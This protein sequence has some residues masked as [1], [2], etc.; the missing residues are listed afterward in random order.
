MVF[1]VYAREDEEAVS[2]LLDILSTAGVSAQRDQVILEG[3]DPW[4][5]KIA[6]AI[7]AADAV[8]VVWSA[9]AARSSNVD[10]E[11]NQSIAQEKRIIPCTLDETSLPALLSAYS[12]IPLSKPDSV[13]RLAQ[14]LSGLVKSGHHRMDDQALIG[15]LEKFTAE[16][17]RQSAREEWLYWLKRL[18][19]S[20]REQPIDEVIHSLQHAFFRCSPRDKSLLLD[21]LKD[22]ITAAHE[23]GK[24]NVEEGRALSRLATELASSFPRTRWWRSVLAFF[25]FKWVGL[26]LLSLGIYFGVVILLNDRLRAVHVHYAAEADRPF[27]DSLQVLF[28]AADYP[29]GLAS[30]EESIKSG[31]IRYFRPADED[32]ALGIAQILDSL[33]RERG[34]E[35]EFE[36]VHLPGY[37]NA[38]GTVEVWLPFSEPVRSARERQPSP[39]SGAESSC[40]DGRTA[41]DV[42]RYRAWF[43]PYFT[44][45]LSQDGRFIHTQRDGQVIDVS[46]RIDFRS[47]NGALE[48]ARLVRTS[49]SVE[50][51]GTIGS[52]PSCTET[53]TL[54]DF[55]EYFDWEDIDRRAAYQPG[56]PFCIWEP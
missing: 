8:I 6:A 23:T 27:V 39:Q 10:R 15:E 31:T 46:S 3:G 52:N 37:P 12:A 9:A 54:R 18:R 41:T 11:I 49:W 35:A 44:A 40:S 22:E 38:E 19:Q 48:R 36:P 43:G 33:F 20:G 1:V 55:I 29:L 13:S 50:F 24:V 25:P 17:M 56:V 14:Q 45:K 26:L 28:A 5:A 7:E 47:S 53:P 21:S 4:P 2:S 32:A 51:C 16:Q 42:I 34:I 30:L